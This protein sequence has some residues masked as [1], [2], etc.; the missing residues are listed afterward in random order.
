MSIA[1]YLYRLI[2]F[3]LIQNEEVVGDD[4]VHLRRALLPR[5]LLTCF[6]MR[7]SFTNHSF[8]ECY[9]RAIMAL[10]RREARSPGALLA[11]LVNDHRNTSNR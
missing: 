3:V 2:D 9:Q 4:S 5:L 10:L 7:I 6:Q 8:D 11:S 1:L